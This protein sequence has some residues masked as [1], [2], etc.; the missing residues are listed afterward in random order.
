MFIN[1][2]SYGFE[3]FINVGDD[4]LF[5]EIHLFSDLSSTSWNTI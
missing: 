3:M 1:V 5:I 4:K 2:M